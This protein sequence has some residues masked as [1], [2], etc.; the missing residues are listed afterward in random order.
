MYFALRRHV[1]VRQHFGVEEYP[2]FVLEWLEDPER[3]RV[4]YA[5]DGRFLTEVIPAFN[6]RVIDTQPNIGS[7]YG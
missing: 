3:A 1:W 5:K 6:L 7:A 4:T 2:G